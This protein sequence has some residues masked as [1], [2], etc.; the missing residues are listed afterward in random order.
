MSHLSKEQLL[1]AKIFRSHESACKE[2]SVGTWRSVDDKLVCRLEIDPYYTGDDLDRECI[3]RRQ[4]DVIEEFL[5]SEHYELWTSAPLCLPEIVVP[6]TVRHRR[7][8][9]I[10]YCLNELTKLDS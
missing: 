6:N 10:K 2:P 4:Q 7:I 9:C 3:A 8:D 1:I 5:Y